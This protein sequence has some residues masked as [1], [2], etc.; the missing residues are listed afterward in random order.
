MLHAQIEYDNN[1]KA[2]TIISE[3]NILQVFFRD[4]PQEKSSYAESLARFGLTM[5]GHSENRWALRKWSL[6][7]FFSNFLCELIIFNVRK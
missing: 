3:V 6:M 7:N 5:L 2:K 4:L 1:W